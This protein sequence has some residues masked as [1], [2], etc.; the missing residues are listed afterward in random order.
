LLFFF[1]NHPHSTTHTRRQHPDHPLEDNERIA[2]TSATHHPAASSMTEP[3]SGFRRSLA[4]R[5]RKSS[6]SQFGKD[7]RTT[8]GFAIPFG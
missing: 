1:E 3:S 7:F 8:V 6:L 5:L 2:K 4:I